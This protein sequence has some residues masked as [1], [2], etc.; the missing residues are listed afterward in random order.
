MNR[1]DFVALLKRLFDIAQRSPGEVDRIEQSIKVVKRSEILRGLPCGNKCSESVVAE[2]QVQDQLLAETPVILR[3]QPKVF[4]APRERMLVG[5]VEGG[6]RLIPHH[7]LHGQ[8]TDW[9]C[10]RIGLPELAS[11]SPCPRQIP[12]CLPVPS[13]RRIELP[14]LAIQMKP[15]LMEQ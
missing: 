8:I 7:I 12:E 6:G 2:S 3:E 14:H 9:Q 5:L 1:T 10:R 13:L 11:G 15:S 4:H